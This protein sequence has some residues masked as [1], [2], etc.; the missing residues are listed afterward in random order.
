MS[1]GKH[2]HIALFYA[3]SILADKGYLNSVLAVAK[4]K[5]GGFGKYSFVSADEFSGHANPSF[6]AV[7]LEGTIAGSLA[8]RIEAAYGALGKEVKVLSGTFRDEFERFEKEAGIVGGVTSDPPANATDN[9]SASRTSPQAHVETDG[10]NDPNL[11]QATTGTSLDRFGLPL[12]T[13]D[14]HDASAAELVTG[15]DAQGQAVTSRTAAA[16]AG[17]VDTAEDKADASAA[18]ADKAQ[19][20]REAAAKAEADAKE[21]AEKEAADKAKADADKA[22]ADEKARKAK[23]DTGAAK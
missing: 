20:D 21:A 14:R 17:V 12:A 19:K 6:D 1:A 13:S 2:A 3:G 7:L 23:G 10:R 11:W 16:A 18:A 9:V 8:T 15:L 5:N 22:D 4:N